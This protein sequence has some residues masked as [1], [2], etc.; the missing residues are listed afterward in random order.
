M[1]SWPAP[2]EHGDSQ[3]M[4]GRDVTITD[5]CATQEVSE[6]VNSPDY[7]LIHTR[8]GDTTSVPR[9]CVIKLVY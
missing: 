3:T 5:T 2:G 8:R 9:V 1:P 6:Q 4:Q 7:R